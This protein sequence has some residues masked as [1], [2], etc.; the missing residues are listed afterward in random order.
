MNERIKFYVTFVPG[1]TVSKSNVLSMAKKRGG[2]EKRKI[3]P[4][5]GSLFWGEE[6]CFNNLKI[7]RERYVYKM[8]TFRLLRETCTGLI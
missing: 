1:N 6:A 8:V 7:K 4:H 2:G 5:F 3:A